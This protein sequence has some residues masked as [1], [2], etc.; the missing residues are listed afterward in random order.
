[1][2]IEP[3]GQRSVAPQDLVLWG[4]YTERGPATRVVM[5]D[6]SVVVAQ[7]LTIQPDEVVV[8]GRLWQEVR[9][10]RSAVR[11]LVFHPPADASARDQLFFRIRDTGP[12][13]DRLLLENGDELAGRLPPAVPPD[14][15]AFQ[16]THI[17][18]IT[19]DNNQSVDVSL[20]RVVAVL[21]TPGARRHCPRP[22]QTPWWDSAT[23]A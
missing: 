3:A 8:V 6:G 20:E 23:A 1:M 13:G 7:I 15:G 12:P 2:F 22:A 16:V 17:N 4:A 21:L 18:W 5:A 19:G 11:A 14:P 9:L 10:P